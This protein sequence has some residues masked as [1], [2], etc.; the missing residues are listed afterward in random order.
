MAERV[1]ALLRGRTA[2][3]W[4]EWVGMSQGTLHRFTHGSI[5]NPEKLGVACRAE[6]VSITWL[7]AGLGTP[8]LVHPVAGTDEAISHVSSLYEDEDWR[9][10]FA[11][12]AVGSTLVMHQPGQAVTERGT[13]CAHEIVTVISGQ[14]VADDV[15]DAL[16]LGDVAEVRSIA[17]DEDE[18][19]RLTTGHMGSTELFGWAGQPGIVQGRELQAWRH[20]NPDQAMALRESGA[21][22]RVDSGDE[23]SEIVSGLDPHERTLVIRMLRALKP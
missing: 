21:T 10:L 3:T 18:W 6:N 7:L 2:A 11:T 15:I 16:S 1:R 20:G 12:S 14:Y 8:Y 4:G 17:L 5:P 23:I 9:I 19:R 13:I 22:Y